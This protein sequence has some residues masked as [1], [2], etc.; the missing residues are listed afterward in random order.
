MQPE[1]K[2]AFHAMGSQ[3]EPKPLHVFMQDSHREVPLTAKLGSHFMHTSMRES[4]STYIM[5]MS[6]CG[7]LA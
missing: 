1:P 2:L 4:E 6:R 7:D 5:P 3:D